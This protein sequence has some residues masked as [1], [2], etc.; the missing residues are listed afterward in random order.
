MEDSKKT[1]SPLIA[2]AESRI[3]RVLKENRRIEWTYIM[4]TIILFGCGVAFLVV[5][6]VTG[7]LIWSSPSAITTAVIYWPLNSIKDIRKKNIALAIAPTLIAN[8]PSDIAAIEMQTLLRELY[9][10]K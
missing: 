8:L 3:D 5:A 10:G 6:L 9:R 1:P 4:L 2:A 7:K